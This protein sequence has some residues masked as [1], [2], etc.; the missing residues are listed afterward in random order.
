MIQPHSGTG[1]VF[2]FIPEIGEEV[3]VGFEGGNAQ[4]PYVLGTQYNGSES[5]GYADGQNN[6]KAIH[7]RSGHIIKFTEDESII[8]T[9]K[10]GNEIQLDT[11]GGN[12][13]ITAPKVITMNATNIIMNASQNIS[14]TAGM[15]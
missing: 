12:I 8:I 5:S 14:V 10:I 9:D 7:T 6:V 11:I 2:Y 15:V 1:K 3:L 4:N 13:N